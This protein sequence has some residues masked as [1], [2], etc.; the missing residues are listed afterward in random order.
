LQVWCLYL[1]KMTHILCEVE[2]RQCYVKM[3]IGEMNLVVLSSS[4]DT[5]SVPLT[6]NKFSMYLFVFVFS[7]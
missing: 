4:W 3:S 5:M 6:R 7:E 2:V 1:L